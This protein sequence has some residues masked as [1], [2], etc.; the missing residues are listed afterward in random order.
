MG[1]CNEGDVSETLKMICCCVLH[2]VE[3]CPF[4]PR[5]PIPLYHSAQ[6][7]DVIWDGMEWD[8]LMKPIL[9]GDK[10]L[11]IGDETKNRNQC[12]TSTSQCTLESYDTA[13][14]EM[15]RKYEESKIPQGARMI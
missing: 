14:K 3:E 6:E 1:I 2:C 11:S 12:L 13:H 15:T 10:L 7:E 8:D 4:L 9:K 5:T